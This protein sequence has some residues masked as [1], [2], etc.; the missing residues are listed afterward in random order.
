M[1][2]KP[3][4]AVAVFS[5]TDVMP[6]AENKAYFADWRIG[7]L[8][9]Q[10]TLA[11]LRVVLAPWLQ[12]VKSANNTGSSLALAEKLIAS[13]D[14]DSDE[15]NN[16]DNDDRVITEL[17]ATLAEDNNSAVF[18]FEKY[19]HHQGSVEL[20]LFMLDDYGQDNHQQ[21]DRLIDAIKAKNLA[22][23]QQAII[24]LQLN[25]KVLAAA[26]L[27]E[28]CTQWSKLLSGNE[29]PTSLKEVNTLFKATRAA[30]NA[31]DNYAESI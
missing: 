19:L 27:E 26:E 31:I 2:S 5:L 14:E 21:L 4:V 12:Y 8:V 16:E 10:S 20:A 29:I 23:A 30:L 25:A 7:Q 11:E 18:N 22:K 24:D 6:D 15:G 9:E 3:L 13:V 17:A 28:L 1:A